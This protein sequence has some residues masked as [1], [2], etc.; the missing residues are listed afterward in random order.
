[1]P[2]N[3]RRLY[4]FGPFC[5]DA[6]ECL[7]SRQGER[8]ELTPK[9]LELLALLVENHGHLLTKEEI[10]QSIWPSASVVTDRN[11]TFN[12]AAV[13]TALGDDRQNG[14]RFIETIPTKGYRFIA[15]VQVADAGGQSAAEARRAITICPYR[16]LRPF[17]EQD[18]RFFAGRE[19]FAKRLLEMTLTR[20]FVA[21]V[22]PSGSGKSSVVQA[23][24]VPLLRQ[25]QPPHETWELLSFTPG[26]RPFHRL[27]TA[28]VPF[29]ESPLLESERLTEANRLGDLL[30]ARKLQ[31]SALWD[32]VIAELKGFDRLLVIGDQFEELF[33]LAP[34]PEQPA[35]LE[36]ILEGLSMPRVTL[37]L[38]LRADFYAHALSRSR[39]LSD[40]LQ[41]GIANLG[42]MTVD[43]LKR[44]IVEPA[45]RVGLE[46]E[47]G[48]VERILSDVMEQPGNLPLLQFA[49]TEL[50]NT[51]QGALLTY[52]SYDSVGRVAGAVATRAEAEFN[53]HTPEQQS[54]IRRL[55]TRM[56]RVSP[57]EE[58]GED[59]RQ[60]I[61]LNELDQESRK[62]VQ[63]LA[64]ADTRLLVIGRD[65]STGRETV[66][67]AH[68]ALIRKWDRVREWLNEDREFLLWRQRLRTGLA[69][70]ERTG[71]DPGS[72]LRGAPLGE[73][74][75]WCLGRPQ[76]LAERE[77]RYISDSI[78]IR[79]RGRKEEEWRRQSEVA[80][81]KRL[82]RLTWGL[83]LL[84]L[85][86]VAGTSF[87]LWQ[88]AVAHARELV[89]ASRATEESDPEI[90]VLLAAQGV[91]SAFRWSSS[92]LPEAKDQ[93]HRSII[94]S[95]VK[96]TL[97]AHR[98]LLW[99]VAWS[100]DGRRLATGSADHTAK[101]WTADTGNE[102]VTLEGHQ[103]AVTKLAWSPDGK[104]LATASEDHTAKV[105]DTA[106]GKELISLHGHVAAVD[107]IAWSP[108]GKRL[109]TA[110]ADRTARV[111]DAGSGVELL[112]FTGHAGEVISVAWSPDGM[113]LAT[114]SRDSTAKVWDAHTGKPVLT[115]RG[116]RF[117]I[118]SVA[119]S[120]DGMRLA[121]GSWDST[122]KIW[123]VKTGREVLNLSGH[124][125][126]VE[127][128]AWSPDGKRLATGGGDSTAKVWDAETGKE[129]LTLRGH[130]D[131]I[132]NVAW[133]PDGKWLA[134]AS[135]DGTAKLWDT[136]ASKEVASF[137]GHAGEV[138]A[139]AWSP[140]GKRLV[141]TSCDHSAKVWDGHTWNEILALQGHT[142][143]VHGVA[144]SPDSTRLATASGD[145]TTRVWNASTG[146][147]MLVLG[148]HTGEV[149]GV[150]WSPEGSR[151]ATAS[152]DATAR[153]WDVETGKEMLILSGDGSRINAVAWSLDGKRLATANWDNTAKVWN[154]ATG[155]EMLI[156]VGH[157][158]NLTSVAWS[159][160]GKRLV[161]GSEDRTARVWDSSTGKD[162]LVLS[163]HTASVSS[164]AW[165]PDGK[166]LATGSEDST[167]KVWDSKTGKEMLTLYGQRD[168]VWGVAWSPDGK[169]LATASSDR[170]V[171]I[172][173]MDIHDLMAL[174]RSRVTAYPSREGC[175][176]FL[177]ADKCPPFPELSYW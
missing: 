60:R 96:L 53:R 132:F 145:K 111:W 63:R 3:T 121:T 155:E 86:T 124:R 26:D 28:I 102:L 143:C 29:L 148:G 34:Q 22:G 41:N 110:S 32:R 138:A 21:V 119:W 82:R 128:V 114:G 69:E 142:L 135:A 170:T 152:E 166:R 140:N 23:G 165:S 103:Q 157:R 85:L 126:T 131:C 112:T 24:L 77:R 31:L 74:E 109:A 113:W 122:A 39:D 120:P 177:H 65:E 83:G 62:V 97:R 141:T 167:A 94:A 55:F 45:D 61:D 51:R 20:N 42:P 175:K 4:E 71:G 84:L 37:L 106:T 137:S 139:V 144:W 136:G 99:G 33:A 66:E 168:S 79:E 149:Y 78:A 105:W 75:R 161:T 40:R 89:A 36:T 64:A 8:V 171:Q 100:P 176:R 88:A 153:V 47:P 150:A 127:S 38:T 134:T 160:D 35:F 172:Y 156:L 17:R 18:A 2:L 54:Q 49:L 12:I 98:D 48:L 14:N 115:L 13:R 169:Q 104:R 93:L 159:P 25:Q 108:D 7:L 50:W 19:A 43:E 117:E 125:V 58:G 11:L 123:D 133:S 70:Y 76:E 92:V 154:P 118:T 52:S 16:G 59:V 9:A 30:A 5:L 95:H 72:L 87:T 130:T 164:V 10:K 91:A 56:V 151:L 147:E 173:A 68:E 107:C 81:A 27:S 158:S 80:N 101:I 162:L 90:S 174:A 163:G 73:A 46:F 57:P 6:D 129:L 15:P 116:H 1:M 146:K 44:A 67:V